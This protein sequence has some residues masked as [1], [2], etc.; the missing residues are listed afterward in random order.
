[1]TCLNRHTPAAL[2]AILALALSIALGVGG[3]GEIVEQVPARPKQDRVNPTNFVL[4]VDPMMR[5]TVAS[6]TAVA[7]LT[8]VV[9]RGYGLVVGLKETGGRLMPAEVRAMM[10]QELAR[11]GIGNPTTSPEGWTPERLLDSPDTAI[12]V[13]EGV[14]PPG[15]TKGTKFDLRVSALPGTDVTSLEGG[16]L[17]T[18]DLRPGPLMV[19]SR[20]AK[21]IAEG[22]GNIFIN[23]FVEP[24]A[25]RRDAVNRLIGRILDGG[26]TKEDMPL[27][28]KLATSSHTRARTIQTAINST[29]PREPRQKNETARGENSDS[30]ELTVPPSFDGKTEDFIQLV[31]HV[32]L[33]ITATETTAIAIRKALIANPGSAEAAMWRFRAL[34]KRALPVIQDL[35]EYPEEEPRMAALRAGAALD[36]P[37][38]VRPLLGMA[39]S[40]TTDN[41]IRA[42]GLLGDMGFNPDVDLG[43][44][45]LLDDTDVDVRLATYEALLKRKDPIITRMTIDEKFDVAIVPSEKE[46]VYV[47]QSGRP[48][49]AVF[50]VDL[51]VERPLTVS[52]WSNRLMVKADSGDDQL[53]VFFRQRP[54]IKPEIQLAN[55]RLAEFIPFLGHTTSVERPLPGLGLSYGE[56]IGAV[57]LLWR[58]GY[59]KC[60]FKAEQDRVLAA[61][62]R[63]QKDEEL[64]ERPEFE[65]EDEASPPDTTLGATG[66]TKGTPSDL[67]TMPPPPPVDLPPAERDTVPR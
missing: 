40:A 61:I 48:T 41:R 23:P 35:Y 30:V 7:G 2:A 62:L 24:G 14:I 44:R 13:V 32:P 42:I 36:D 65:A 59:L 4:D 9:V 56:T 43:L 66:S 67:A 18:T 37:L 38:A 20:Q 52:A 33:D 49:I 31:R 19:G 53:Q 64:I 57:H 25:T 27:K 1:M 34:G 21:I 12:V 17:Y 58:S 16:R 47:A 8:P 15:A 60:D 22:K 45:P 28:L 54:E 26:S 51:S 46:M 11:R 63:S 5:G 10:V 29:F 50:G 39:R 3:C 6:E 55:P